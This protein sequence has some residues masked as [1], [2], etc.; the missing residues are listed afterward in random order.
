MEVK[1]PGRHN[2]LKGEQNKRAVNVSEAKERW[3]K[4]EEKAME[5]YHGSCCPP[6]SVWHQFEP[7]C[8][9]V[10]IIEDWQHRVAAGS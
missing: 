6:G 4:E 3:T 10:L 7:S 9:W 1:E 8:Q 2:I 5:Y